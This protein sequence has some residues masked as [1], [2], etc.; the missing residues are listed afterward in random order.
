MPEWIWCALYITY[1]YTVLIRS[2]CKI[3]ISNNVQ[4][5]HFW[6]FL[7]HYSCEMQ[8]FKKIKFGYSMNFIKVFF[9]MFYYFSSLSAT[10]FFCHTNHRGSSR[11]ICLLKILT[12]PPLYYNIHKGGINKQNLHT[13]EVFRRLVFSFPVMT[14]PPLPINRSVNDHSFY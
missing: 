8:L 9:F 1:L 12:P 13:P 14:P 10:G 5:V 3:Y 11:P 4:S 2:Q 7:I 6:V